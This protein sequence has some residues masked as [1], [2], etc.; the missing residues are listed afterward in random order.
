MVCDSCRKE[1]CGKCL[2]AAH[3]GECD[4]QEVQFF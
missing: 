4:K 1:F 3:Q 2:L